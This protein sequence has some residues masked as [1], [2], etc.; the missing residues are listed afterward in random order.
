MKDKLEKRLSA[1]ESRR[2]RSGER[3]A[4]IAFIKDQVARIE[5]N[6]S[7]PPTEAEQAKARRLIIARW[8]Q[9]A[10]IFAEREEQ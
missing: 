8:P 1:I 9:T 2:P 6:R 3:E 4:A 5:Q 7:F 10:E